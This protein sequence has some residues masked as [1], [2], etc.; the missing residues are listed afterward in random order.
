MLGML[1]SVF[2]PEQ[3]SALPPEIRLVIESLVAHY[4]ARI[5]ALECELQS[6]RAE[7]QAT[8]IELA[9]T[10]TQLAATQ[11]EL[12]KARKNSATSSKPPSS[13]L[14]KPP[15]PSTPAGTQ[16]KRG[17]QAG[18]PKHER[19][20]F[21]P[22]Q[23]DRVECHRL[24]ACPQCGG[25]LELLDAPPRVQQ[26]VEVVARPID[27]VEHRGHVCR[28]GRCCRDFVAPL[29]PAVQAAGLVGPRLTALIGYLKGAG[30]CS[31]RT[32]QTFLRDVLTVSLSTGYLRKLCGKVADSLDAAYQ[33]LRSA[34]PTQPRLNIDET[35]HKE[36]GDALWTWCFRAPDFTL[37][38]ID[39]SRSS[40]VLVE[41]L[42]TE[43][44]GVI[45]CDYFSAYRK[46]LALNERTQVQ[47]CWAHLI[48][49]V[50]FLVEHP[51]A[52]NR[53]YGQR[54]LA[55]LRAV[56]AILHRRE[57]FLDEAA[58]RMALD[59][60]ARAVWTQATFRTPATRE[61]RNLAQRFHQ[62][63]HQYLQFLTTPQIEPT[64]NLAE[65]AIRF[66]VLDR[67]VTQ[68]TRSP[69]GRRWC[70]RLWTALATCHQ[71]G[72]AVFPFLVKSLQAQFQATPPP[73]LLT[74]TP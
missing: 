65:Q 7:L 2:T 26:Q 1:P 6:T 52:R 63:G 54:L 58:F 12:A 36:N 46:Y 48:R 55:T 38:Q 66:V 40:G 57:T 5:A 56:F 11:A 4:E 70:E 60:Q 42:G 74:G 13:D 64:N 25:P 59:D 3:L 10:K 17:G 71:T 23:I 69:T 47:F 45:G 20:P 14:V 27:V 33:E 53:A 35:G 31:F 67:K 51:D 44:A 43:F 50:K 22:D 34:L 62:H 49:D 24:E 28:C 21:G 41:T 72:R 39:P 19:P 8:Q 16:R 9:A 18:H 68:G 61:A 32:I 15:K 73:S 29:P 37:F 30:H